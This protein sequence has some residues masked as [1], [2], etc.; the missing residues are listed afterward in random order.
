MVQYGATLGW[1]PDDILSVDP[2]LAR[3]LTVI[4]F[5]FARFGSPQA[6]VPLHL[7]PKNCQR[8]DEKKTD[9][10]KKRKKKQWRSRSRGRTKKGSNEELKKNPNSPREPEGGETRTRDT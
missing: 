2:F 4:F 6:F 5:F 1:S 8:W 9:A 10:R 7:T 3:T